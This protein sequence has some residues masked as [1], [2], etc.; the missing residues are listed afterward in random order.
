MFVESDLFFNYLKKL[1]LLQS[2][3]FELPPASLNPLSTARY[4]VDYM[5]EKDKAV[6]V[7]LQYGKRYSL[8]FF[9]G[10]RN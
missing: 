9:L 10:Q 6:K 8:V 1:F 2:L 4:L 3:E 7:C 5:Q